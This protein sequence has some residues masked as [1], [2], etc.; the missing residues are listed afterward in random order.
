[1][2]IIFFF[3]GYQKYFNYEA[4]PFTIL[5]SFQNGREP[6]GGFHAM[7]R[8]AAFLMKDLVLLAATCYLLRQDVLRA[9]SAREPY[10]DRLNAETFKGTLRRPA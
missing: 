5:P 10:R 2:V 6:S 1:M 8:N 7:T 9:A 3:F 4:Q